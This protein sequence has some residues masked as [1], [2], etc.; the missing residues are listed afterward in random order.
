MPRAFIRAL[1]PDQARGR[2]R[3]CGARRPAAGSSRRR[4]KRRRSRW[5][6]GCYDDQ[7]PVDVFQTG[8]GTSSNM[9][10]NEVIATLAG[11]AAR[12]AGAPERSREHGPEQQRRRADRDSRRRPRCCSTRSCCRRC[13]RLSAVLERARASSAASVK[14]GRTHLMDAMPITLAQE[15]GG[16]RAQ[17]DKGCARLER[18]DAA[19]ARARAGRHR[20][21]HRHQ[22]ATE[23]FGAVFARHLAAETRLEFVPSHNYF[24]ALS[25]QDTAVELSG[26]LKVVAVSLMKI[27]NDL[28]WMNS[29]PL[30]GLGGDRAAGAAARQQHHA[31]QGQSGGARSR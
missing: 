16:W 26:Q 25:C 6:Q 29:G 20:G 24:E 28:R 9:N 5:R 15:L 1:G 27:S 17:I 13:G 23:N 14:T 7:F 21:G 19:A 30:A 12:Q 8:S 10:A 18:G 22:R 2:G 4:S 11:R 3:E 31:G